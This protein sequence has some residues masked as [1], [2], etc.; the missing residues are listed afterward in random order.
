M[1]GQVSWQVESL[2]FQNFSQ[3]YFARNW[4]A[5][6]CFVF[7]FQF[8]TVSIRQKRDEIDW[9]FVVTD[10]VSIILLQTCLHGYK[11]SGESE[12]GTYGL[13]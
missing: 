6:F 12:S 9:I 1:F 10:V 11:S 7:V 5:C 8:S 2:Y 13:N 3:M 4:Q